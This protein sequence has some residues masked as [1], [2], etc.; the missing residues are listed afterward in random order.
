MKVQ[1]EVVADS[2]DRRY[3]CGLGVVG[4][5]EAGAAL[6][7]GYAVAVGGDTESRAGLLDVKTHAVL[8][9]TQFVVVLVIRVEVVPA[10]EAG[11]ERL[12]RH[13]PG[14]TL[15]A[16]SPHDGPSEED[17]VAGGELVLV[18]GLRDVVRLE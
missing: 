8:R 10:L 5:D 12:V 11:H 4:V 14:C 18:G 16:F 7:F 15:R 1:A 3:G 17:G 13:C 2:L 9:I 6:V